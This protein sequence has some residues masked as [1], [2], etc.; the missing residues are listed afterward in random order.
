MSGF[1][2]SRHKIETCYQV[3]IPR[4][5]PARASSITSTGEDGSV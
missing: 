3:T 2:K 5:L 1:D 4:A